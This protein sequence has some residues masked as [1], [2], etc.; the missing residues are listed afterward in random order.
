MCKCGYVS[1]LM[2]KVTA[3]SSNLL[4]GLT[5]LSS[6]SSEMGVYAQRGAV[7]MDPMCISKFQHEGVTLKLQHYI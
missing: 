4:S 6:S 5:I 7:Y 2:Q 3:A 1:I